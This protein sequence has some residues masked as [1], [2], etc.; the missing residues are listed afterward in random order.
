MITI[1]RVCV[2]TAGRDAGKKCVVVEVMDKNF[3]MITG[4]TRRR[5][6]NIDHLEPLDTTLPIKVGASDAAVEKA[7]KEIGVSSRTSKPKKP[8][9][10]PV[11]KRK[12]K[13][14]K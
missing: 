11:R 1:G 9:A 4:E 14:A 5:K 12:G 3:V 6:C 8:T 7:L 13:Q 10:K 2:K